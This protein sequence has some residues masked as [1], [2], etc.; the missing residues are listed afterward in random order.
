[1]DIKDLTQGFSSNNWWFVGKRGLIR[2]LLSRYCPKDASILDVGAGLGEDLFVIIPFGKVTT[3]DSSKQAVLT[4]K[5]KFPSV[6]AQFGFIEQIKVRKKYDVIL[7][8]DVLEHI[9]DDATAVK[10]IWNLLKPGGLLIGTVPAWSF[11]WSTHDELLGHYRRYSPKMLRQLLNQ[12]NIE[13]L[14]FWNFTL[15]PLISIFKIAQ[16]KYGIK[17]KTTRMPEH[18]NRLFSTILNVESRLVVKKITP[19]YG[20]SLVFV[21]RRPR[22]HISL[23]Q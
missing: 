2:A 9:K 22:N 19:P 1:M 6:R 13:F 16:Q 4:L 7:A 20:I 15:S 12:F 21:C 10:N 23:L 17:P 18:I 5:S 11:L 14:Q 3:I 8:F